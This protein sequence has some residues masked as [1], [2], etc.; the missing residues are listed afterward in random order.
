MGAPPTDDPLASGERLAAFRAGD[1]AVLTAVY[2]CYVK[3]VAI[4]VQRGFTLDRGSGGRVLGLHS[5]EEQRDVVQEVFLRAFQEKARHSYQAD[6]PYR[7]W[8]LR[9]AKNLMIDRLRKSGREI[10][11]PGGGGDDSPDIDELCEKNEPVAPYGEGDVDGRRLHE[12]TQA[13]LA[14]AAPEQAQFVRLRFM[15]GKSQAEVAALL[16][17]TRRRVRTEEVRARDALR[18]WL[19]KQGLLELVERRAGLP[20]DPGEISNEGG[21]P[22][23]AARR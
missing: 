18:D 7:P 22:Q 15:E 9:I 5:V 8:L 12:A 23:A 1:R 6:Q 16:D 10:L 11:A 3:D 14:Q 2:R 21:P 4:L 20:G 17:I 19:H 13:F